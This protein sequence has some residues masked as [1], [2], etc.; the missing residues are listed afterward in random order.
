MQDSKFSFESK[1]LTHPRY[2]LSAIIAVNET[3][4]IYYYLF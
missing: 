1:A 3:H 4:Q 2:V